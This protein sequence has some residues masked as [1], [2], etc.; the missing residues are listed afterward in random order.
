MGFNNYNFKW[1][2]FEHLSNIKPIYPQLEIQRMYD[3]LNFSEAD[4]DP[5]NSHRHHNGFVNWVLE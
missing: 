4:Y 2:V 5:I 3:C 1:H